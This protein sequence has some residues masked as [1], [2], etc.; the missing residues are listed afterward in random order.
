MA[1]VLSR[2]FLRTLQGRMWAENYVDLN[3]P[4]V[5]L[6]KFAFTDGYSKVYTEESPM[7]ED[8]ERE[9]PGGKLYAKI[10]WLQVGTSCGSLSK[11]TVD[12][13]ERKEPPLTGPHTLSIFSSGSPQL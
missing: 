2:V 3:L 11:C 9:P 12:W 1:F 13:T 6:P 10:N 4:E 7:E 8:E 5:S